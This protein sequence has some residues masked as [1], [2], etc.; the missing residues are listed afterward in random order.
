MKPVKELV[1]V[2]CLGLAGGC[3]AD[4]SGSDGVDGGAS[5]DSAGAGGDSDGGVNPA[6]VPYPIVDTMQSSCYALAGAA[7]TCAAEGA[8]LYGQDAQSESFPASY[9]DNG[10][11]TVTDEV[12]GLMWQQDPGAKKTFDEA[13]SGAS[14]STLAGYDDWRLPTIK[15]LYSLILFTGIDPSG[16]DDLADCPGLVPFID[17]SFAFEYGDTSAN[18]RIIDAQF[19]TSTLYVGDAQDDELMFGVNFADGRIK[20]YGTGPMPGSSADKSFFVLYVRGSS[21]YGDNDFIDNSD[22]TLSDRA[23]G[24][25]WMEEDSGSFSV[26][27]MADG[28]LDWEQALAWADSLVYAGYDDWRLPDAKELHSIVDYTRSPSSTSSAAIDARFDATQITNEGGAADYPFYW[29]STS[30][31]NWMTGGTSA[32]YIAFGR[33]LGYMNNA[34][35]DIHGA[36]AQRSDPKSG[37]P[38]DYPTGHGPQGDAIR[39]YNHVRLVRGGGESVTPEPPD[40]PVDCADAGD[41]EACCGD[42]ECLAPETES[43]CAVDCSGASEGPTECVEEEDCDAAGACPPDAALGCSCMADPLGDKACIPN[44]VED[45]DCPAPP[46]MTLVCGDDQVCVPG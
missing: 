28:T 31:V 24:L 16:C 42:D 19:A 26:G 14:S 40:A 6:D 33:A 41:G 25:M 44:C 18:E 5:V 4:G 34:W 9:T 3:S 7:M 36:G 17:A 29:T 1:L 27:D 46:G 23:T 11:G 39:I 2:I 43:N 12:T 32:V 45:D 22:G 15:E 30:H 38:G 37:D 13:V 10:D 8:G 20:G 35:V 21:A